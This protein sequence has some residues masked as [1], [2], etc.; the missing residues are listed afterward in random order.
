MPSQRRFSNAVT[1]RSRGGCG[2]RLLIMAAIAGFAIFQFLSTPT[3]TNPFTGEEQRIAL[4]QEEEI[5]LGLNS[6]PA[7][8]EQFGGLD[9]D[10]QDTDLVRRIGHKLVA[11]NSGVSGSGYQFDFHL[12]ADPQTIN[13]F[14]LPGGQIFITRALFDR[15]GSEEELAGIL[16]HEIGHVVGRHSA[17]QMTKGQ[18]MQGLSQ[19]VVVGAS[20]SHSSAQMSHMAAQYVSQFVMTKYGRADELHSDEIGFQLLV[21]SGYD[22]AA[23]LKVM[24]T[25]R[26]AAGEGPRGPEFMSTH[27]HPE[28]RIARLKEMLAEFERANPR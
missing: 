9:P 10:P 6:A 20:D 24:E 22:P 13:A 25:L 19:A 14:A 23:M 3:D 1:G 28:S 27:P 18:L 5:A 17:E 16:G 4:N 2:I 26:D 15:L 21:D 11:A 7:M 12:L 8:A